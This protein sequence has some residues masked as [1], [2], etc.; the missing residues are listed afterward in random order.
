MAESLTILGMMSGS[1]LDGVDL[2]VCSFELGEDESLFRSWEMHATGTLSYPGHLR[3]LLAATGT[4]P[5]DQLMQ[6]DVQLGRTY[7]AMA[8]Q[9]L[10]EYRQA[11]DLIAL[12]GHTARH[13]PAS[14]YSLQLG[15]GATVATGTNRPTVTE[16]RDA[17]IGAGGQGAPLAP[18]ADDYL[19]PG[20]QAYLN[21]GGIANCYLVESRQGYDTGAANQ[22][23]NYLS[24]QLGHPFDDRGQL[25]ASGKTLP[26]LLQSLGRLPWFSQSPP[27]SLANQWIWQEV[28]P[29]ID[30]AP[31]S[32]ID[33]LHTATQHVAW[34]ISAALRQQSGTI[35]VSGGGAHNTFLMDRIRDQIPGT[36]VIPERRVVDYKEAA[37]VALTG[38]FRIL[39]KKAPL[40]AHTGAIHDTIP[41]A[42]YLPVAN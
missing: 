9:F 1:S 6:L 7:A 22:V 20:H 17:D 21:I 23:L 14:G 26:A 40:A 19:W 24:Q 25:A 12:H 41:G 11:V 35:L 8:H 34:H 3:K 33:K 13:E 32:T 16:L 18:L 29:L 10:A 38:L 39:G 42:L 2:A 37:L 5:I 36:L 4:L 28:I 27:K 30:Q 31:G 15:A